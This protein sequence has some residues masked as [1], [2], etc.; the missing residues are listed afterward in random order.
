MEEVNAFGTAATISLDRYGGA[1]AANNLQWS[2]TQAASLIYYKKEMAKALLTAAQRL[3][4]LHQVAVN[5]GTTSELLTTD[6]IR[7]YQ[8][9][10]STTG[11]TAEEISDAKTAGLTDAQIE[12]SRQEILAAN[13]EESA[14]DLVPYLTDLANEF[15]N[16]GNAILFPPIPDFS[17][18]GGSGG[19][20][21]AGQAS[22]PDNLAR[23]Q[24]GRDIVGGQPTA[25]NSD[26]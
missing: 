19:L 20:T 3:D 2:S 21:A 11:F 22:T 1:A 17:V 6:E 8:Q 12:A 24:Y 10:L 18:S 26:R 14:G 9:R 4:E 15:R 16:L 7:A 5:E 13:P 23:L 25:A